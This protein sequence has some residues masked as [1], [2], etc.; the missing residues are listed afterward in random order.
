MPELRSGASD[1][2]V[3]LGFTRLNSGEG[4]EKTPPRPCWPGGPGQAQISPQF[5]SLFQPELLGGILAERDIVLVEQRG[6]EH[7]DPFLNCPR[8]SAS[9]DAYEKGLTGDD[10][11]GFEIGVL[12][13]CIEQFKAEGV[14]STPTTA[15]RTPPT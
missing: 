8:A 10:V 12:V 9:W 4:A 13:D 6:T 1:G 14:D 15:W 7:T 2:E 5:F 11:A 3:K